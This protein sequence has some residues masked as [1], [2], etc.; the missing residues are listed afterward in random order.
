MPSKRSTPLVFGASSVRSQSSPFSSSESLTSLFTTLQRAG[1]TTIDTAQMY[2]DSE[3]VLGAAGVASYGFTLDT[4]SPG[5][6]IPGSL[7]PTKLAAD[8]RRSKEILGVDK[9]DVFYIH[10]PDATGTYPLEETL[11]ILNS[12]YTEGIFSRL[13]LSN[14]SAAQVKQA[15]DI[16]S[17]RGWVA[18]SVFQGNYSAF[19]RH[20]EAELLPTLRRLGMA[21]YAY[22]PLAGGFLARRDADSLFG[23]SGGRFA[24]NGKRSFA[25]YQGLY[26][27]KASLV[28]ALGKWASLADKAGCESPAELGYR[29]VAWNGGLDPDA[30]DKVIIGASRIEQTT[31]VSEWIAKGPLSDGIVKEIDELWEEVKDE[32]PLD[33][34]HK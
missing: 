31:Q 17:E 12:L 1:I 34:W 24:K 22:S 19:A 11:S 16:C 27:E 3:T 4:K 5:G 32:A 21:F 15:H 26:S 29:W 9:I 7:E 28:A 30:G 6:W 8:A 14:F 2:A 13:G 23:E 20:A 10:G 25:M 18:P 33:N